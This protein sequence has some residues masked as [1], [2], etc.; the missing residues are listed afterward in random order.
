M[1]KKKCTKCKKELPAT[2]KYFYQDKRRKDSLANPCRQCKK[3]YEQSEHAKF[4]DRK[5]HLKCLYGLNI[6]EY[7]RLFQ[8]QNGCCAICGKHQSELKRK[9]DVDHDHRTNKIRGLVCNYCNKIIEQ[10][11][12][13]FKCRNYSLMTK[14]I[15]YL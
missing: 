10:Y 6:T 13:S 14:I 9:L 12:N 11:I 3:E 2:R 15:E 5:R 7:N 8:Q 1:I 4:L